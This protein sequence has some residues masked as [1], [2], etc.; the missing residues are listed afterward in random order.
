MSDELVPYQE[1]HAQYLRALDE[2]DEAIDK[3]RWERRGVLI[4]A[5]LGILIVD[6]L[7][8][9][10]IVYLVSFIWPV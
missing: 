4:G 1:L 5:F 6:V 2:R 10:L 3:T 7:L 8:F 9:V